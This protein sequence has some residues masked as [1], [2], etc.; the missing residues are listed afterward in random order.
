MIEAVLTVEALRQ[1][2]PIPALAIGDPL[3][4]MAASLELS[5]NGALKGRAYVS[6]NAG[7]GG[8][9]AALVLVNS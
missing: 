8:A 2:L 4:E 7:F 9:N 5:R 3:P 6:T 1:R